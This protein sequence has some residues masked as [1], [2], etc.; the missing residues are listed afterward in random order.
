L[1]V[2][3]NRGMQ[4]GWKGKVNIFKKKM[5]EV[6]TKECAKKMRGFWGKKMS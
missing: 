4:S 2:G 5:R 6:G 1:F 3:K